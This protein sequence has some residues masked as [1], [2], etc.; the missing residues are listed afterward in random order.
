[1]KTEP[2]AYLGQSRLGLSGAEALP[3][4]NPVADCASTNRVVGKLSGGQDAD[5]VAMAAPLSSV[6]SERWKG[7]RGRED[8]GTPAGC[9]GSCSNS[10]VLRFTEIL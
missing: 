8:R 7:R 5:D 9:A 4:L 3:R 2:P 1:M 6:Y 10:N